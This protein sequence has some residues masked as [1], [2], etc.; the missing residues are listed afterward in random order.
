MRAAA[1]LAAVLLRACA[2]EPAADLLI[3]NARIYTADATNSIAEA[4]AI[5]GDRIAR[6]GSDAEVL[7]I[8]GDATRVIDAQQAAIVP[9]VAWRSHP[10]TYV[11]LTSRDAWRLD[12]RYSGTRRAS[13]SL[14]DATVHASESRGDRRGDS[15]AG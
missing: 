11:L 2:R 13:G 9:G 6:V 10:Q 15:V 7:A 8:R 12:A 3:H 1:V 14:D 4:I 5:R